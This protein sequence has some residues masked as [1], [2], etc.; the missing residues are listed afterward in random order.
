MLQYLIFQRLHLPEIQSFLFEKVSYSN[1]FL[2]YVD[3]NS[4]TI[5]EEIVKK[6]TLSLKEIEF[7]LF[8]N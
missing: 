7:N 6:E 2:K 1:P 5:F 8:I 4:N 3:E